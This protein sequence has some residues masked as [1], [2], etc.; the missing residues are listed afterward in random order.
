MARALVESSI[1]SVKN[2]SKSYRLGVIGRQTLQD[3][4]KYRWLR[5]RGKDPEKFMGTVGKASNR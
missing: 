4:L 2:L 5:L 3:E 1:I